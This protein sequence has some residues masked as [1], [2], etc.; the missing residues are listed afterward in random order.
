MGDQA[1]VTIEALRSLAEDLE[2]VQS[3]LE[4]AKQKVEE[5]EFIVLKDGRI[6]FEG[7]AT[8]LRATKDPYLHTYLSGWFP[9]L[10]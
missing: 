7:N 4:Q 8:E 10:I 1:T 9:P 3:T 5:A 6:F 2:Q